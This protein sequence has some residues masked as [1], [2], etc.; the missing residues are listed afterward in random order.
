MTASSRA[1]LCLV[2]KMR[3]GVKL[4]GGSLEAVD[5]YASAPSHGYTHAFKSVVAD[6][7]GTYSSCSRTW[8]RLVEHE[9]GL[10]DPLS[11][12]F[13]FALLYYAQC[14]CQVTQLWYEALRRVI[15]SIKFS[16]HPVFLRILVLVLLVDVHFFFPAITF[17]VRA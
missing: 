12:A 11:L 5:S 17:S 1:R 10:L 2:R 14:F 7:T 3:E 13:H 6:I 8:K 16:V 15:I 4:A 9:V